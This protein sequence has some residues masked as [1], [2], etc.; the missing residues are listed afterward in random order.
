MTLLEA[1]F[2]GAVLGLLLGVA[3]GALRARRN[4]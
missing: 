3:I 2:L 4:R 1:I